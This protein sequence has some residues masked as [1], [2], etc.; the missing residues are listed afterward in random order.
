MKKKTIIIIFFI[1]LFLTFSPKAFAE[2]ISSFNSKIRLEKSGL[3]T[4]TE[5]ID[6]DFGAN[7][8]HGIF[9]DIDLNRQIGDYTQTITVNF[10][11]IKRDLKK[12]PYTTS[13]TQDQATVKIGNPNATITGLH[14]YEITYQVQNGIGN[15][16][17]HDELYWNVTGDKWQIPINRATAQV[18]SSFPLTFTNGA[19][20][21]GEKG[22]K[23]SSCSVST[24]FSEFSTISSLLSNEGL[25]IVI[26]F[27]QGTFPESKLYKT[28]TQTKFDT[29]ILTFLLPI[30][31]IVAFAYYLFLPIFII[32]WYFKHKRKSRFG[33]V[34]VNFDIPK[35]ENKQRIL[36]A[37]AGT[38]DT[39]R[40]DKDDVVATI[41]D[42]AIR[43]YLKIIELTEKKGILKLKKSE[44]VLSKLKD[45]NDGKVSN[46]EKILLDRLFEDGDEIKLS[47]LNNDFY[48]TFGNIQKEVFNSLVKKGFYSKNPSNMKALLAVL[49]GLSIFFGFNLFLGIVLIT[50]SQKVMGRT[51]KGDD[52]DF[53]I[54]GLKL[55]LKSMDRNYKWQAKQ[56]AIVEDMIPYAIAL[57]YISQF[58]EQLKIIMPNYKPTWYAGNLAFYSVS[59]SMFSS[60]YSNFST[61]APSSSSGFSGGGSSGG[62]GGGGGGGSW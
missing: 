29:R 16:K 9:R 32:V 17:D 20:F 45:H 59:N 36:P 10:L 26:G 24:G 31:A 22:S 61:V 62:G 33:E 37:E 12:E 56:L 2:S 13:F 30:F 58:M 15:Y 52:L 14:K 5:V 35:D 19:C 53:R 41:F 21:T 46:F 1:F 18:S 54:D 39:A 25:T 55:F 43:K 4:V 23:E 28:P 11:D 40:L 47:S 51:Q 48:I 60:M 8:R 57:G 44:Y 34:T 6:Y 7:D 49:G 3:F 38:I 42:L 27:P 50:I